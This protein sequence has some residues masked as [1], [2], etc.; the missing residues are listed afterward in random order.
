MNQHVVCGWIVGLVLA[1]TVQE[2]AGARPQPR[3]D[4]LSHEDGVSNSFINST[5]Q[6]REGYL[7]I[8]TQDGLNRY[9]GY[10]VLTY[11]H[12]PNDPASIAGNWVNRVYGDSQGRLWIAFGIGGVDVFDADRGGFRHCRSDP[13]DSES[14][15][16]NTVSCFL[17]DG[18]GRMWL[19]TGAGLALAVD[20][21]DSSGGGLRF[22][23][24]SGADVP[25][26]DLAAS[27]T[28]DL[29]VA[30]A[31]GLGRIVDE[32]G[33]RLERVRLESLGSRSPGVRALRFDREGA[34]WVGTIGLGVFQATGDGEW[35]RRL[36][37][38]GASASVIEEDG[39]GDVWVLADN[40][41]TYRLS[42]DGRAP[43]RLEMLPG[44]PPKYGGGVTS[45]LATRGDLVLAGSPTGLLVYDW[46][47]ELVTRVAH[48]PG[49]ADGLS[50]SAISSMYEDRAGIVW[51][52]TFGGGVNK[53]DQRRLQ[54]QHTRTPVTSSSAQLVGA[55]YEAPSGVVWLGT[56]GG[57]ILMHDGSHQLFRH[58][59]DDAESLSHDR[60]RAIVDAGNR[61]WLGTGAGLDELTVPL[62]QVGPE[63][64]GWEAPVFRRHKI[65]LQSGVRSIAAA[66]DGSL[67][68]ATGAELCRYDPGTGK[69]RRYTH[70]SDDPS[71]LPSN[72]VQV[73]MIDRTGTV[74]AGT[75][76]GGLSRYDA[77]ADA[78]VNFV[79]AEDDAGGINSKSV[80]SL[81]E[82]SRGRFWVG[83]YSGG[84]NEL[85]RATGRFTHLTVREGLAG[86]KVN[87]T[88]E[89]GS[90]NLWVSTNQGLSRFNPE[91]GECKNYDWQDGLQSN[92]FL[93]RSCF[94]SV[95]GE[96]FFGGVGGLNRFHPKDIRDNQVAPPVS[97]TAFKKFDRR[98]P[99]SEVMRDGAIDLLHRD[100]FISFEFAALDFTNPRKNRYAYRLVGFDEDWVES[101]TRRY[102]AYT[103]LQP[104]RYQF[105]VKAANPDGVWNEQGLSYAMVVHPPFWRRPLFYAGVALALGAFA[106]LLHAYRVRVKV[107]QSVA[108]QQAR[109]DE[110]DRVR[111]Q[112][113]RDYHDELGHNLT[114]ISLF[115]ELVKRSVDGDA[116]DL[117][118]H[119]SK[120]ADVAQRLS[121]DARDFVW[122]LNPQN[123]S[124]YDVGVYLQ[125]FGE[126]LFEDVPV[127]FGVEGLERDLEGKRLSS[128]RKRHLILIVKE[129]M[130]NALKYAQARRVTLRFGR[131]S[132]SVSVLLE[133]DGL[134]FDVNGA[135]RPG[136]GLD[137]MRRRS[138]A[139]D[140]QLTIE[141]S[142]K[143]TQVRIDGLSFNAMDAKR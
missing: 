1:A 109:F 41:F 18:A 118:R 89:D 139:M 69:A 48:R 54:F 117:A 142:R 8:A 27:P 98:V 32:E 138:L 53:L 123:D 102:A 137:N 107:R 21:R 5:H 73:V 23:R 77:A 60:I 2:S 29:W 38:D 35:R 75:Y 141:S 22:E 110:R 24:I 88:L 114:K 58:R 83:T 131:K 42:V 124:L 50:S 39:R 133:D 37:L 96:L 74:W 65:E 120:V 11:R 108:I 105:Q 46:R 17:E 7:W 45:L 13:T 76:I 3:F 64:N 62:E 72:L 43:A 94:R 40:G 125:D 143:G 81:F 90:G 93:E 132:G 9:D 87:G 80:T 15:P 136:S 34:L 25:V 57:L 78:F 16:S 52:G 111:E 44:V 71:S 6:D 68:L 91:T 113:A 140:G 30:T 14:L 95:G 31:A 61:V 116:E 97:L 135:G 130:T 4:V 55:I 12:D 49:T 100:H 122:T 28:G 56:P 99:L 103:N 66:D 67:W 36:D 85:D 86:N 84:L 63:T 121:R 134:G 82:D 20:G 106:W 126:S 92:E 104:G 112:V 10:E 47:R 101:G 19:G 70:R 119:V 127:Q 115:T 51:I 59:P 129:A 79:F 26:Y 128:D 33:L